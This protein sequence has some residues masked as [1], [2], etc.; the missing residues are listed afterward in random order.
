MR[1][2]WTVLSVLAVAHI[3]A[4]LGFIGWLGAS[5]RLDGVRVKEVRALFTETAA[6]RQAREEQ[7]RLAA[8]AE[9]AAAL[10][11]ERARIPPVTAAGTLELK[12]QQSQ[13]DQ[14]RLEGIRREVQILQDTLRR[15]REALNEGW[16]QL[17]RERED[18]ERARK[19][20]AETEGNT[21][22]KKTLATYENLKPEKAKAA[23]QQL[24]EAGNTEQ[25]IAYL[26]AMQE[27]TRTKL[28]DEFI[29]DDPKL[30]T[31]LLER[32]RTRGLSAA[33]G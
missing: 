31:D 12:L 24:I 32:L 33:G 8:E 7:E 23:L 22:F 11:A 13:A 3:L 6:Q 20:V 19:L 15:E 27:R 1:L 5:D 17:K 4:L 21:Q 25:A 30:A 18:F 26:N 28:I 14:A 9:A 10:E 2:L 29:K 16:A